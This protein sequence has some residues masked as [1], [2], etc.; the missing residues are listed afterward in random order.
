MEMTAWNHWIKKIDSSSIDDINSE[1][2]IVEDSAIPY[3]E[4]NLKLG[5]LYYSKD[6]LGTATKVFKTLAEKISN[7]KN[8]FE[9]IKENE[10][11]L[12]I[13]YMGWHIVPDGCGGFDIFESDCCG[14]SCG[15]ICGCLG[16]AAVMAICGISAD[17]VCSFDAS[18][19]TS[20]GCI[21][22]GL[23]GC[24]NG[25]ADCYGCDTEFT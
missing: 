15:P 17:D 4:K 2:S 8:N 25:C 22:N 1:I 20:G 16:I 12:N 13:M 3:V 24:C 21:G 5:Y 7:E 14:D 23:T 9:F 10:K 11:G 6:F 19:G 18:S